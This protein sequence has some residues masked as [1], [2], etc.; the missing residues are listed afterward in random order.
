MGGR[1]YTGKVLR[2]PPKC[3]FQTPNMLQVVKKHF[4]FLELADFSN[5]GRQD[6]L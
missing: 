3:S 2:K 4:S 5:V 6:V 1:P